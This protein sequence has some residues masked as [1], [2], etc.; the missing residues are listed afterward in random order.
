MDKK[1]IYRLLIS[2]TIVYLFFSLSAYLIKEHN[3]IQEE[4]QK[5]YRGGGNFVTVYGTIFVFLNLPVVIVFTII[6]SQLTLLGKN[7]PINN[8]ITI[9]LSSIL[10]FIL[11]YFIIYKIQTRKQKKKWPQY[12]LKIELQ[13]K[14]LIG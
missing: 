10:Y 7:T 5:I 13:Q 14:H 6:N 12:N 4:R 3:K 11:L 9:I 1:I 2:L 8:Q